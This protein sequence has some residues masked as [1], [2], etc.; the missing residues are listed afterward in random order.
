MVQAAY[1]GETRVFHIENH[2]FRTVLGD[3]LA[4]F[5]TRVG[6]VN[7]VKMGGEFT[8]QT[9]R[10]PGITFQNYHIKAHRSS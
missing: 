5:V 10:D 1:V 4:E 2:D 8:R 9:L 7:S 3:A 6:E